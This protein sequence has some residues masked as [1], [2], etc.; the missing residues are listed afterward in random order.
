MVGAAVPGFDPQGSAAILSRINAAVAGGGAAGEAGQY[1]A[2]AALARDLGLD[3]MEALVLR[4]QG[5]FGTG[6][7]AFG[8]GSA[9]SRFMSAFGGRQ[10]PG[11]AAASGA[12]N[13][14]MLMRRFEGVYGNDP[15][16]R[17]STRLNSSH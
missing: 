11:G 10:A 9:Y 17:K 16:D 2:N 6:A 8:G 1:F 12:T 5:M 14:D 4:E 7:Q 13:I 15:R 3:P